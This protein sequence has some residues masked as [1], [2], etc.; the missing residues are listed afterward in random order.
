MSSLL[1]REAKKFIIWLLISVGP[2]LATAG[3][4]VLLLFGVVFVFNSLISVVAKGPIINFTTELNEQKQIIEYKG[5]KYPLPRYK[6]QNETEF[7]ALMV[8]RIAE[9]GNR[10]DFD[11]AGDLDSCGPYQQRV[12]ELIGSS[13]LANKTKELLGNKYN[14]IFTPEVIG[15]IKN[16]QNKGRVLKSITSNYGGRSNPQNG[17]LEKHHGLDLSYSNGSPVYT[18]LSGVVSEVTNDKDGG[19]VIVISHESQKIR[20]LYAHLSQQLV[21]VGD[22]VSEGQQIA[23]S[24][25]SGYKTTGPHLHFQ[26]IEGL[27]G[28]W[29][30]LTTDPSNYSFINQIQTPFLNI[31]RLLS[32][33]Q[34]TNSFYDQLFLTRMYQEQPALKSYTLTNINISNFVMILCNIQ[35]PINCPEWQNRVYEPL[36]IWHLSNTFN[37]ISR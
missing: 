28:G 20:T 30:V 25:N 34:I 13:Y 5:V 22:Q 14:A 2:F 27:T 15:M 1:K 31:C 29:N 6:A 12:S 37:T 19:Q 36:T 18:P 32:Y 4:I 10:Q 17:D 23:L 35:R 33:E 26:T 16:D 3:L 21:K 11:L 24:G 9:F 8:V 7:L